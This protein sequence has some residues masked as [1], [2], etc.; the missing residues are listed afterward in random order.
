M[1]FDSPILNFATYTSIF[2]IALCSFVKLFKLDVRSPITLKKSHFLT[3]LFTA[4]IILGWWGLTAGNAIEER[5]LPPLI[6]PAPM[7]VVNA[8]PKL[9]RD[10]E[11][12]AS[13]LKS[14]QRIGTGFGLAVLVA[15]PLG[16]MMASYKTVASFFKPLALATSYSPVPIFI[17]L[18]IAWWGTDEMQKIG[19]LFI[20]CFIA[21]LPLVIKSVSDVPQALLDVAMTK[22]ASQW[23][24]VKHVLFPVS[25]ADIWDHMRGVY[26]VGWGWI[27]LAEVVNPKQGLGYLIF[28]SDRRSNTAGVFAVVI[29]IIAIAIVL[30]KLWIVSGQKMFKH[31]QK[32]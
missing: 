7:E 16:V 32:A 26:A 3:I 13:I 1:L 31:K 5:I 23:Q 30:D 21:L 25:L 6:L 18:T 8:F 20:A 4:L 10:Q 15:I 24:L 12:V 19:F 27:I 11:L 2:V 17:P 9:Y 28:L 22:G 29:T 14:F